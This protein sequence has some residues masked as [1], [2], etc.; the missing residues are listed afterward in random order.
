M[1]CHVGN[2]DVDYSNENEHRNLWSVFHSFKIWN[3]NTFYTN[4]CEVWKLLSAKSTKKLVSHPSFLF[5]VYWGKWHTPYSGR[6]STGLGPQP[7]PKF[8][9]YRLRDATELWKKTK[10]NVGMVR[11]V[12]FCSILQWVTVIRSW[13]Q[14]VYVLHLTCILNSLKVKHTS[15]VFSF[16]PIFLKISASVSWMARDICLGDFLS[17]SD[18]CK[19]DNKLCA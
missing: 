10:E 2:D 15:L 16:E 11:C 1:Q 12:C 18:T 14:S 4:N 5:E 19:A 17:P 9:E 7:V 8:Q 6:F 13:I 3:D